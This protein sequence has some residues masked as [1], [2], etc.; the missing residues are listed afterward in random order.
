[1]VKVTTPPSR[2]SY[3]TTK[4]QAPAGRFD[5]TVQGSRLNSGDESSFRTNSMKG[6]SKGRMKY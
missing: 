1:M 4:A 3:S 6:K 5:K 2:S